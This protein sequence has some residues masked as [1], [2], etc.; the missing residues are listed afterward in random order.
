[1]GSIIALHKPS[2][3]LSHFNEI[4]DALGGQDRQDSCHLKRVSKNHKYVT[5]SLVHIRSLPFLY[6]FDLNL[7]PDG[8]TFNR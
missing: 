8:D 5:A 7:L 6:Y 4:Y 1:M 2:L 3:I